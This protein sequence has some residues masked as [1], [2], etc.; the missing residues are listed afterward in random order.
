MKEQLNTLLETARNAGTVIKEKAVGVGQSAVD[1]TVEAIE[2]WLEEFPKIESYG[3]KIS[4]FSFIMRLSPSLD[5]E[6]RGKHASFKKERLDEI[7]AE[8]KSTSLTGMVFAAIR[9]AYRLHG[10]IASKPQDPII[11]KIRLSLS[12][13]ISVFIGELVAY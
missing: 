7:L 5:V 2:R 3:L 12:P 1:G 6:L 10:K 9:T 8:N 11:V 4:S 13:E